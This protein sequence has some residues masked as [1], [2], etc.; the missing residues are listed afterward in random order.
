MMGEVKRI[1]EDATS[2]IIAQSERLETFDIRILEAEEILKEKA[3][4][5]E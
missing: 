3:D 4:E 2:K 1:E 5:S